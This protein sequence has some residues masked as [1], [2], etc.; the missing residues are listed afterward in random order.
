MSLLDKASLI[1]VP[2]AP[3]ETSAIW[4]AK[5]VTQSI[6]FSR[7]GDTA[8]RANQAGLIESV[9]ADIPRIDFTGGGCGKLSLEP[10]RTNLFTR[11]NDFDNADWGKT[12][13]SVTGGQL[14]VNVSS[15]AFLMTENSV[16]GLHVLGQVPVVSGI[17]TVSI[18][19][20]AGTRNFVYLRGVQDGVNARAWFNLAT[21]AVGTLEGGA[22]AKINPSANG[23]YKCEMTLNHDSGFEFYIGMSENDGIPSYTG[24]GTGSVFIQNAQLETGSV[25]T[26]YIPTTNATATRGADIC[27][28]TGISSLIGQ[29]DGTLYAEVDIQRAVAGTILT[30]DD[31]D[32]SDFI[33]I[34][35]NANLTITVSI[36]RATG[37]IVNII[38]SSAVSLGIH[39]LALTYTNGGYSLYIDGVSAGTSTNSTDYPATALTRCVLSNTEYGPLNDRISATALYPVRLSNSELAQLTTL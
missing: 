12:N 18:Y 15:D 11:S 31:G 27:S 38:T 16:N 37:T 19:A 8:T 14:G 5:P 25:A 26:S 3:Q 33:T 29:L 34:V 10:Q 13:V 7:V 23:Y 4:A 28:Q 36:R 39:K 21:G 6:G 35:K 30:I 1:L 17:H 2:G 9:P 32:I 22:N 20:K 24:N